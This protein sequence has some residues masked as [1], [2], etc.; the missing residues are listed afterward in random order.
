MFASMTLFRF[1]F[2][3]PVLVLISGCSG[4]QYVASPRYVPLNEK[5]GELI[6]NVHL[7]GVQLG[8]SF[9]NHFSVFATGFRRVPSISNVDPF[10][11]EKE[12]RD[13]TSREINA[14]ISYFARGKMILFETL[15]G[16]GRGDM[17]FNNVHVDEKHQ[18]QYYSFKM[19]AQRRN[20]FIQPNLSFKFP[21]ASVNK[22]LSVALFSKFNFVDYYNI[23]TD[24]RSRDPDDFDRGVLYFSGRSEADLF[25][26]EPGLMVKGGS[27]KFRAIIQ[28]SPVLNAGSHSIRYQFFSYCVG[29]S[30]RLDFSKERSREY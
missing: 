26:I 13:C 17:S 8:Y 15:I 30:M 1:R 9:S 24:L 22:H 27:R 10:S 21:N 7:S 12:N 5:K 20:F 29:A 6:A 2:F 19:N 3:V 25:F 28:F 11:T 4:Y 23:T 14:G 18:H 16:A